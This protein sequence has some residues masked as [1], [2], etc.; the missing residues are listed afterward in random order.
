VS[1]PTVAPAR[2]EIV[3]DGVPQPRPGWIERT[4]SADHKSVALL[5][6]GGALAFAAVALIELVLMRIQLIVPENTLMDPITFDRILSTSG[7]TWTVLFAL[8][9]ALGLLCYVVPLQIGSRGVA[10]PRVNLLSAW[11]YIAGGVTIYASF[12]YRPSEAGFAASPPLS[13]YPFSPTA[14]VDAWVVGT[15]LAVLGFVLFAVN[16]A[17]TLRTLRAP[18]MA[19]RRVPLF[20]WAGAIASH[21]ILVVGPVMLAALTMV[22]IDR[23]SGGVFFNPLEG[24]APLLY[25]HFTSIFF[26]GLFAVVIV[27]AFGAISEILPTFARKPIFSHRAAAACL[28]AIAVL[29]VLGWIRTMYSAP[30]PPGWDYLA[31]IASLALIV[32]IGLVIFNW[33]STLW[34]GAL[35]LRAAPLYAVG[36]ICILALGLTGELLLSIVPVGWQ[37]QNTA[38]ADGT[39]MQLLVGTS[40][41]GG[42]AAL[43]YWYPKLTGRTMGEGM[44][45]IAFVAIIV[46]VELYAEPMFLAGLKAQP[47]DI[48]KYFEGTGVDGYNLIASIGAFVL[49]AGVLLELANAAWS[50]RRGVRVGHDP[51]GGATLEWFAVSPPPVHNFDAVP[52]VRSAEPLRDIREWIDRHQSEEALAIRTRAPA[53][54]SSEEEK[55]AATGVDGSATEPPGGDDAD[56]A[57]VA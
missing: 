4:T 17:A 33:V 8:P 35:R 52:D 51:W 5:Y 42:F 37:L 28:A 20:S 30:I 1:P 54:E 3:T 43:H 7:V 47:A 46:G 23:H 13:E 49:A 57:P 29:S 22:F 2:S 6:I 40:V 45:R 41:L 44:A 38:A 50:Y 48:Y 10:L 36:A 34:G 11:L 27:V 55:A 53:A 24:G 16:L 15:A 12:L 32:P 19:W 18:G 26:S 39:T 21:V 31:M 9:L 56:G 25:E 14:G